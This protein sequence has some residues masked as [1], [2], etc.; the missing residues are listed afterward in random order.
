VLNKIDLLPDNEADPDTVRSR[1][2]G[3]GASG[4]AAVA[5]SARTGEGIPELLSRIDE[6]LAMDPVTR[7][8]FR[9]PHSDGAAAHF[10]HEHARVVDKR[11]EEEYAEIVADAPESVRKRL[12]AFLLEPAG[13]E[14]E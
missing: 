1:V 10:L 2:L 7:A 3:S 4:P 8:R 12:S 5:A 13:P 6:M 9:I 14:T 11:D